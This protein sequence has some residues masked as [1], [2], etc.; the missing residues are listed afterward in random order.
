VALIDVPTLARLLAGAAPPAV[1]DV[2]WRLGGPPGH[3]EY[4]DGHIPGAAFLDLDR[5]LCGPPGE[6]GRHPLPDPAVLQKALRMAGVRTGHPVVVYD[7]GDGQAAARLWWTLRW[8]G[9]D[10]VQ[11]LDGGFA[12]WVSDGRPIEPGTALPPRGD[13]VVQPGGMPVL[14]ADEAAALPSA[15]TLLD[16]RIAPRFRGEMEPVD[17][18]AGHIPGAVNM[19]AAALLDDTGKL[20]T[21]EKLRAIFE[22]AG[23]RPGPVG[24]YCGSGVTAAQ[25][26]LALRLAGYE[27][28]A[29]YVGSWSN[30]CHDRQRPIALGETA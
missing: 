7:A 27:D 4:I 22:E 1:I 6:Q 10:A 8:V 9:H 15:G 24:A 12:A 19:P 23:V 2:R 13:I 28:P 26:V 21:P 11:V 29:L 25:T 18:V 14:D 30:W 3:D 20:L 5:E 16:A 17:P